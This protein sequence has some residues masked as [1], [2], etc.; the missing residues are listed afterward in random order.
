MPCGACRADVREHAA[1]SIAEQEVYEIL[2]LVT[3]L[4]NHICSAY[5]LFDRPYAAIRVPELASTKAEIRG[6]KRKKI[7]L[8]GLLGAETKIK[9]LYVVSMTWRK[10]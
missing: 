7:I 6:Q 9:Y 3:K 1:H 5:Q 8:A 4:E 2:S 10:E